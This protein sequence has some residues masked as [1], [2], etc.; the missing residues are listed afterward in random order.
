MN[1]SRAIRQMAQAGFTIK[2]EPG[3]TL[4]GLKPGAKNIRVVWNR[5]D[6]VIAIS[7]GNQAYKNIERAIKESEVIN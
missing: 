6:E 5:D 3:S 4:L 2:Y 1:V 7:I